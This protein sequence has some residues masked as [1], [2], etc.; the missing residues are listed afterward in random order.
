MIKTAFILAAG[1]GTRMG[2]LTKTQPKVLVQ[3]KGRT[4]LDRVLDM[5]VA[6]KIERV[7]I[8]IHHFAEQIETH[9][10]SRNDIEIII[11]DERKKLLETGGG[12]KN[13]LPLL[14]EKT[15]FILNG[16]SFWQ[17]EA[18]HDNLKKLFNSWNEK[19]MDMNLLLCP[20]KTA[21]GYDGKGDFVRQ[22]N[23]ALV[24]GNEFVY[25][26]AMIAKADIFENFASEVF[27]T[28]KLFNASQK[29]GRLFGEVLDGK[30]YHVGTPQGVKLA[31]EKLT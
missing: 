14:K 21:I 24:A 26:G 27:S 12:I 13:A 4:L 7:V 30:W 25:T 17:N 29:S 18:G 19:N 9:I 20:C 23:G 10:K 31:E 2:E 5:L 8:N 28:S 1:L 22:K 3:V 11:S 15:F 16:D 6:S